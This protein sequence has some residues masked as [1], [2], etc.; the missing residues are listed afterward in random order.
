MLTYLILKL[1]NSLYGCTMSTYQETTLSF[2]R[3]LSGVE[4]AIEISIIVII[5]IFEI[6]DT[7]L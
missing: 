1:V 5:I 7:K 4:T 3:M 2:F 6:T